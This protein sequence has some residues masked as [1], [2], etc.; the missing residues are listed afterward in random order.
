MIYTRFILILLFIWAYNLNAQQLDSLSLDR[1]EMA[2]KLKWRNITKNIYNLNVS[3]N[4]KSDNSG[5]WFVD[6]AATGEVYKQLDMRTMK[7]EKIFD[8]KKLSQQLNEKFDLE[9]KANDLG[10]NDLIFK[11]TNIIKFSVVGR[12]FNYDVKKNKLTEIKKD[13]TNNDLEAAS[14][15]GK[16]IAFVR[17]Y[18]LYFKPREG[19]KEIQLSKNGRKN[20]EYASR[21]GWFDMIEGEMGERPERFSVRWSP[22]SK[23]IY[24]NVVDLSNASKMYMLD[25]SVDSLY[26]P[27]LLSYYRGSP[28]DTNIVYYEPVVFDIETKSE[29]KIKIA[30]IPHFMG[31]YPTWADDGKRLF[32]TYWDR[33]FQKVSI[34]E[35]NLKTGKL[36]ELYSETSK[37]GIE[38][39]AFVPYYSEKNS[40]FIF[41]SEKSGWKQ[42]YKLDLMDNQI[43][44]I[45]TGKYFV[46]EIELLDEDNQVIYFSAAGK[47]PN[48][49]PYHNYF[50]RTSF[51]GKDLRPLTNEK[52]HHEISISPDKKYF[53]DNHSTS[54][55]PTRITLRETEFGKDVLAISSADITFLDSLGWQSPQAFKVKAGDGVTDIY[56]VLYKPTDFDPEKSYP[57]IDATYTGPHTSRYPR[58]YY[59]T[60]RSN[61]PAIAELG[62][63]LIRV[64]GR[65]SNRRSQ[66]FRSYSYKNLGG[67]LNDHVVA[68]KTLAKKYSWIDTTRVGIFGHSAGGYDAGRALLAYPDFYKVGVASSADHDHRME[69]AWWPEMYM[70]WPVGD[71]YHDQSNITNAK[72]LKGKL[73][74]FHGAL[75]DNVNIS[76]TMKLS[77]ALVKADKEFDL[78]I[79]PSQR[80][81]YSGKFADY[82]A[83]K[84]WNYFVEHLLNKTPRWDF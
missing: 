56:G 76:A 13:V 24:S 53:V 7:I 35:V 28:G 1:Y 79:F 19:G 6:Q 72:N 40:C 78:L 14:P 83:K 54:E 63:V 30:P 60:I 80:H 65:G 20:Y 12:D 29:V 41:T 17:D 68:M 33:G 57:I 62:F 4:W 8:H 42:L 61:S 58:S 16:W 31:I 10:L 22:D 21:Y 74:L 45:T 50:Y 71:E 34:V 32:I 84:R 25:Y 49:N 48:E 39:T 82:F 43:T 59:S 69:K 73:L 11:A 23:K 15:D 44:A 9:T 3:P 38:Y 47:D 75:D 2:K 51:D 66:E 64:D 5:F 27:R 70:G 52:G 36:E 46:D 26:R 77:E 37:I 18:N 67:G 81:G 55:M